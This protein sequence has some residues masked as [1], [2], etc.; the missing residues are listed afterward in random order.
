MLL[1]DAL[2]GTSRSHST[3][4]QFLA[5]VRAKE[6]ERCADL[7]TQ[8]TEVANMAEAIRALD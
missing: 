5:D 8:Y 4:D 2:A 6:R 1:N 3:S 7:E